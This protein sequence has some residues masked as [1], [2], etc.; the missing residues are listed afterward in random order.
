MSEKTP[1]TDDLAFLDKWG[2][3]V[4]DSDFARI[5]ER[6]NNELRELVRLITIQEMSDSGRIFYPTN[7]GSCRCMDLERI[8]QITEK[9]RPTPHINQEEE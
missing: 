9:Y 8:G 3:S 4:V 1:R 7:V 5:L 6:E 2:E